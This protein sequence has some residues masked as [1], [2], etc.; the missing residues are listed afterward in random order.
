MIKNFIRKTR[1]LVNDQVL[2]KWLVFRL[3]ARTRGPLPFEAHR[4]PYLNEMAIPL[5]VGLGI[6]TQLLNEQ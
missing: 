6:H 2:R 4:P 1:Q 3:T 5:T